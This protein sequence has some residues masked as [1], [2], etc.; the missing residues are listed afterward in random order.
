MIQENTCCPATDCPKKDECARRA[1]YLNALAKSEAYSVLNTKMLQIGPN[2]C[3][4]FIVPV[5]ERWAYGFKQLYATIP[6]GKA[7]KISWEKIFSSDSAYYRT[8][9]GEK[10]IS[11][12]EQ[13]A[14]LQFIEDAGGNPEAGFDR[15]EDVT[16]YKKP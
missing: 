5:Q 10:V 4:H 9:R 12:S 2:G 3:K 16:V 6:V 14:I 13:T 1:F 11:P 7:R 8:K 15:Y